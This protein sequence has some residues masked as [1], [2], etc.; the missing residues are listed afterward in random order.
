LFLIRSSLK[1]KDAAP[2][3]SE[4]EEEAEAEASAAP[5]ATLATLQTFFAHINYTK[6]PKT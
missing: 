4:E 2:A 5:S 6:R 1:T 3:A